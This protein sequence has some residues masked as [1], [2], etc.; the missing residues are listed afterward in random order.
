MGVGLEIFHC[1]R[2]AARLSTA[3]CAKM[4][5]SVGKRPPQ[6]GEARMACIGCPIGAKHAGVDPE[7]AARA[8]RQAEL[9]EV[10]ARCTTAHRR[11]VG[12]THCV[13]CYNRLREASIGRDARGRP[14]RF[15]AALHRVSLLV[16]G[17]GPALQ[18]RHYS[19]VTSRAEALLMAAMDSAG[20]A[21]AVGWR[22]LA[23]LPSGAIED[24]APGFA[25]MLFRPRRRNRSRRR[26][27]IPNPLPCLVQLDFFHG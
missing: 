13:N 5:I 23:D 12:K 1:D 7:V 24:I 10:C 20:A 9:Q 19:R 26:R 3:G 8:A 14:P 4:W 11:M 21:I 6:I 27:I 2:M 18:V 25:P 16:T 22:R 17:G 15:A